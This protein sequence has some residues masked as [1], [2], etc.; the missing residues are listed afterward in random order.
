MTAYWLMFAIPAALA[1][2]SSRTLFR[3]IAR[4]TDRP[5]ALV[6]RLGRALFEE[7]GGTPYVTCFLA[8]VDFETGD[9]SWVNAGHPVALVVN[10][11]SHRALA[12]TGPPAGLLPPVGYEAHALRLLRRGDAGRIGAERS[13]TSSSILGSRA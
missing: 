12:S 1:M 3:L 9:V 8:R 2:E 5:E 4:D 6:A 7:H 13:A 10:G 11:R